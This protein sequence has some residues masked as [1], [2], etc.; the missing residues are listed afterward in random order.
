MTHS[1]RLKFWRQYVRSRLRLSSS[2]KNGNFVSRFGL[3]R[4]PIFMISSGG[5]GNQLFIVALAHEISKRRSVIIL[6]SPLNNRGNLSSELAGF[7]THNIAFWNRPVDHL[8]AKFPQIFSKIIHYSQGFTLRILNHFARD[9][10]SSYERN[11]SYNL[12]I[13]L[14]GSLQRS[15]IA[16]LNP[17]FTSEVINRIKKEVLHSASHKKVLCH[18]RRGDYTSTDYYGL[19]A[20]EYYEKALRIIGTDSANFISD[21]QNVGMQIATSLRGNFLES[22]GLSPFALLGIMYQHEAIVSANSS[23]SWWGGFLVHYKGGRH[24]IPTPWLQ[25]TSDEG[26]W[27]QYYGSEDV[28]SKFEDSR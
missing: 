12:G 21:D 10:S 9:V 26:R 20:E 27:L 23:L 13:L 17:D 18:V 8:S 1:S 15:E 7:C 25:G 11:Q 3:S 19:L 5:L 24:L 22:S 4:I 6:F 16:T 2:V 14:K 28:E